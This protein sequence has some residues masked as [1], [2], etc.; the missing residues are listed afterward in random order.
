MPTFNLRC[1]AAPV[2]QVD[3]PA[4]LPFAFSITK[5]GDTKC[6]LAIKDAGHIK[7]VRLSDGK[8]FDMVSDGSP[9]SIRD[10]YNLL[11]RR[12][13]ADNVQLLDADVTV[14]NA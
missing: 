5:D 3:L 13:G 9:T 14:T 4:T 2:P 8:L 10:F 6:Y 1:N 12:Y 11:V 7:R